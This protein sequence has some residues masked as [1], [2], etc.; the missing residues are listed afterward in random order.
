MNFIN[1]F[2][3]K[4]FLK[5]SEI[6]WKLYD[7]IPECSVVHIFAFIDQFKLAGHCQ[8]SIID[9]GNGRIVNN[10]VEI[11]NINNRVTEESIIDT[12]T[13]EDLHTAIYNCLKGTDLFIEKVLGEWITKT[14][15]ISQSW[16][17]RIIVKKI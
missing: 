15:L 4:L 3:K 10:S 9:F 16:N 1:K 13:H 14:E 2:I 11:I 6:K 5:A 12:I 17:G 7:E 8:S